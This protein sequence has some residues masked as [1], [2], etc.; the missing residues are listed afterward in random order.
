MSLE[1]QQ[2]WFQIRDPTIRNPP[3][4]I[5]YKWREYMKISDL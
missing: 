1:A 4:Y 3:E 5:R 2:I